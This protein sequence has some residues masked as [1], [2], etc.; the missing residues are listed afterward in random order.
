MQVGD[1]VSFYWGKDSMT[2]VEVLSVSMSPGEPWVVKNTVGE[3]YYVQHFD[4]LRV[5]RPK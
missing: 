5:E 4:R 2:G 3:V 1:R